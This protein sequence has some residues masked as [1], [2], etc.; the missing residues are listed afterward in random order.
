MRTKI[1]GNVEVRE[2]GLV[3]SLSKHFHA[4]KDWHGAPKANHYHKVRVS[5]KYIDAHRLIAM[6]FIDNPDNKQFV[7]HIN[8]IKTDNRRPNLEWCTASENTKHAY[9]KG[10]MN[11]TTGLKHTEESKEKMRLAWIERRKSTSNK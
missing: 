1:I 2:D 8:G 4:K 7:N 5:G 11:K 3:R 6:A 9:D 10:L